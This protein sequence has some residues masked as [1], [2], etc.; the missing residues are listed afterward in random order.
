MEII[1]KFFDEDEEVLWHKTI[2]PN[3]SN[4]RTFIITNKRCYKKY[5]KNKTNDFSGAPEGLK[6]IEDI[7]IIE[8]KA[9]KVVKYSHWV[10]VILKGEDT[11]KKP[12]F[13]FDRVFREEGQMIKNL[14]LDTS[15][16]AQ[17]YGVDMISY[18]PMIA[19]KGSED[20]VTPQ[21]TNVGSFGTDSATATEVSATSGTCAFC[22]I[23]I[24]EL[25]GKVYACS[26][27]GA[28]FHEACLNNVM[29]EGFCLNCNKTLLW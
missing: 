27:C 11:R 13:I 29:R 15:N 20:W 19:E 6:V 17:E 8:R 22:Q 26:S 21:F 10:S 4:E 12:Y 23:G 9:I 18:T 24:S 2:S 5:H 14:L 16:M 1:K 25:Q 3:S 7:L 28:L